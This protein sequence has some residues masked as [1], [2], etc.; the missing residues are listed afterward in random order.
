MED[1][2]S[3]TWS[4]LPATFLARHLERPDG[5]PGYIMDS[6]LQSDIR[7]GHVLG[8]DV[9]HITA[10]LLSLTSQHHDIALFDSI[11]LSQA[12]EALDVLER[13]GDTDRSWSISND[14]HMPVW[15]IPFL[16]EG[17]HWIVVTVNV[18][19]LQ[20]DIF[21]IL[22][23]TSDHEGMKLI[24][25]VI[26]HLL[27]MAGKDGTAGGPLHVY[28]LL[29]TPICPVQP[30]TATYWVLAQMAVVLQGFQVTGLSEA[31]LSWFRCY[32]I[33]ICGML[34]YQLTSE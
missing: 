2:P 4:D 29:D 24:V 20:A 16:L 1:L 27:R 30:S 21:D 18:P 11:D 5:L 15:L 12:T 32:I 3:V 31:D 33:T 34:P 7:A 6:T 22:A 9:M 17:P 23:D 10:V 28:D 8:V 26:K 25:N 19:K 14:L 13:E